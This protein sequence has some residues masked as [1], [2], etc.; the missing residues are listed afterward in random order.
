M[1]SLEEVT[2]IARLARIE[3]AGPEAT[4]LRDQLNGILALVDQMRAVDTAGVEPMAHPQE[5]VQR[6]RPDEVREEDRRA[7]FQA[8][9][10]EVQDGL[11]LVPRVVE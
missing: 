10:P 9:A 1:L 2:R 8:V 7:E 5:V 6:L 4:R 11:Y 3:V